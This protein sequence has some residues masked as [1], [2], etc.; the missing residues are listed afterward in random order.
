MI[1]KLEALDGYVIKK[2]KMSTEINNV[3]LL[4]NLDGYIFQKMIIISL[5][6]LK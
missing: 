3:I 5:S 6:I 2:I 4:N 1:V